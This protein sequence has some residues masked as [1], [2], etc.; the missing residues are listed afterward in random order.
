MNAAGVALVTPTGLALF[1]KRGPGGDHAG[2]WCFPCGASEGSETPEDT[3]RREL[4]EET[5]H[6]VE[7]RLTEVGTSPIVGNGGGDCT[8][9]SHKVA[10]PFMPEVN[11][12]HVGHAWAPLDDPPRPLH[13]GLEKLIGKIE[14]LLAMD[15]KRVKKWHVYDRN[16]GFVSAH[17]IESEAKRVLPPGGNIKFS[18]SPRDAGIENDD[19]AMDGPSNVVNAGICHLGSRGIG[20]PAACGNSRAHQTFGK[21]QFRDQPNK[22]VKCTEKLVK[23]DVMKDKRGANDEV[24]AFDRAPDDIE[25]VRSGIAFDRDSVRDK[26]ANG[27][28]H[29][30]LTNISKANVCP[31]LGREIPNY[32][33]LGLDPDKTYQLLRD[34][35]ELAKA[36]RTFNNIQLLSE[37]TPVSAD[38]HNPDLVIGSTGTDAVYNHPYLQ[39]SLV[40]WA[41]KGGIDAIESEE[42]KQLSS[43]YRYRADMTPGKYLGISY[44]GVMRDIM[45]NHVAIVKV[46]RV[47]ADI[48]VGDSKENIMSKPIVLTRKATATLGALVAYLKPKLAQDA[49]LPNFYPFVQKLTA[50]NFKTAAPKLAQDVMTATKGKLAKDQTME[51]EEVAALIDAID[52]VEVN[53]GVDIDEANGGLPMTTLPKATDADNAELREFLASKG[54]SDEDVEA[55]LALIDDSS[56]GDPAADEDDDKD[57]DKDKKK[58]PLAKD[59]PPDFK[60]KPEVTKKAMDAAIKAATT[61]A[62]A[63]A[64]AAQKEI[65][66]AERAVRPYVGDLA[67][68]HDSAEAVYRAAL[69]L[70][71]VE[72]AADIHAS[73]LPAILKMQPVPGARRVDVEPR[74][75]FDAAGVKSFNDRFPGAAKIGV[76]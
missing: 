46:G 16:G 15:V 71:G 55:A 38:D 18:Y 4:Q 69:D 10:S 68:A 11:D 1:L 33:E 31:Y 40:V 64:T 51:I 41:K 52:K 58:N 12:E 27:N 66:D 57:D 37:H 61:A 23:W 17:L 29:V 35:E 59:D 13:P 49:R 9:F 62:T 60:G 28:L 75:G 25:L 32:Q 7:G 73:A 14:A 53:E 34:P 74:M 76:L 56:P 24:L 36:A 72:G 48:V 63:A 26:D 65:R 5:G 20:S 39:N 3:A 19:E 67:M 44:D 70:L 2:E 42:K 21:E 22:C 6:R 50:K 43:A 45:G 54:L 8:T 47:G 30:A